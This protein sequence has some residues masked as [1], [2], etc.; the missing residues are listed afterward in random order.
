MIKPN[1]PRD[2]VMNLLPRSLCQ[3]QVAAVIVDSSGRIIGWG[4]NHS[5][6]DGLGLCAER[7]AIKRS[8]GNRLAGGIVFVAGQ[9]KKTG[10]LVNAIPCVKCQKALMNRKVMWMYRDDKGGWKV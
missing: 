3:V 6:P 8:N 7:H 9:W 2:L 5:G 10:K 1:D 4:W